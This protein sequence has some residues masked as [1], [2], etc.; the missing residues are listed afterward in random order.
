[1][2]RT[3]PG[4]GDCYPET[5]ERHEVW[6]ILDSRQEDIEFT[7]FA[8]DLNE[9]NERKDEIRPHPT[10]ADIFVVDHSAAAFTNLP[11]RKNNS[12]HSLGDLPPLPISPTP[13]SFRRRR[14]VGLSR[15]PS[16]PSSFF[17][18]MPPT[19]IRPEFMHMP[20]WTGCKIT[21]LTCNTNRRGRR[22][23]YEAAA[24]ERAFQRTCRL[25]RLRVSSSHPRKHTR[26]PL[27]WS[28]ISWREISSDRKV[29]TFCKG[30]K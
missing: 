14:S 15:R 21:T 22:T 5:G 11:T 1:M 3:A 10:A 25:R 2:R 7:C 12:A 13:K 26:C 20:A 8:S 30:M 4:G 18:N 24:A 17:Q 29:I 19:T 28:S 23:T 9:T 16:F 27:T 6:V